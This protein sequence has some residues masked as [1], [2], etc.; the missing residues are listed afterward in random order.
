L[1]VSTLACGAAGARCVVYAYKDGHDPARAVWTGGDE[2]LRLVLVRHS[3]RLQVHVGEH[4]R[5][6]FVCRAG[7]FD[8]A[9]V[10]Y[11]PP[12]ELHVD[13]APG[14][15]EVTC[16]GVDGPVAAAES[17][18]IAAGVTTIAPLTG[19]RRPTVRVRV[20][21]VVAGDDK[22]WV[23][24]GREAMGGMVTKW[25]A[26]T[27]RA[28]GPAPRRVLVAEE[29]DLSSTEH[30]G[31]EFLLRLPTSGRYT[32]QLGAET[33]AQRWFREVV[34]EFGGTYALELPADTATVRGEIESYPEFW[35]MGAHHGIVGPRLCFEPEG[36]TAFGVLVPLPEP[37]QFTEQVPA[38]GRYTAHHHLY[39]TGLHHNENGISGG[40]P[41]DVA[42][43]RDADLGR[44]ERGEGSELTLRLRAAA[45]AL[46]RGHVF[47]RDRMWEAWQQ[48]LARNTTLDGAMDWI[49][50]PPRATI[51]NGVVRLPR[52]RAGRLSFVLSFDS[53]E[54]WFF[55]RDVDP[56]KVLQVEVPALP[57]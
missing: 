17:V 55:T 23:Y 47:V 21:A 51:E 27:Q 48:D 52:I 36:D 33:R 10:V 38:P 1:C 2:P 49:P 7:V 35:S 43:D 20:P 11:P 53:G 44:L 26:Y 19:D 54:R 24:G 46:P 39:E 3:G 29:E 37:A 4:V 14:R 30:G 25:R 41:F 6:V 16:Y 50:T 57:R 13:L 45:G 40:R 32:I 22:W 42:L 18:H 34:T 31:R 15:Y 9:A 12:G 5:S 8:Y 28:G 56:G